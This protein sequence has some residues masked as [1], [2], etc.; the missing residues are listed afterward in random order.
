MPDAVF[1]P[2]V[3]QAQIDVTQEA[4]GVQFPEWLCDIY[5]ATNGFT[6]STGI[7]YLYPI[8]APNG[9]VSFTS[10]IRSEWNLPWLNNCIIF[11][12]NGLGGSCTMHWAVHDGQLIK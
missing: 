2:P 7:S 8:D 9:L 5:Q 3:T 10:F 12:N 11:S 4:V 6:G 1:N